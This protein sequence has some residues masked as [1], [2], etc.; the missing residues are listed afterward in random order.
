M[1]HWKIFGEQLAFKGDRNK[2][3]AAPESYALPQN[4]ALLPNYVFILEKCR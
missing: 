2:A 3:Q 1:I 4:T